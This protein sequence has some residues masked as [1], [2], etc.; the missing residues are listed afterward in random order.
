MTYAGPFGL[1]KGGTQIIVRTG[2]IDL[3]GS[4]YAQDIR[5]DGERD[6]VR[7]LLQQIIAIRKAGKKG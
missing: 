4:S 3:R 6:N 7:G 5:R 1:P 2:E